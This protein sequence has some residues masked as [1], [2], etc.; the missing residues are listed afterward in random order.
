MMKGMAV[1]RLCIMKL[2]MSAFYPFVQVCG[3]V[4]GSAQDSSGHSPPPGSGF[5]FFLFFSIFLL[6]SMSHASVWFF[7]LRLLDGL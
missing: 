1:Y 6:S 4:V 5:V 7:R 3:W 2:F